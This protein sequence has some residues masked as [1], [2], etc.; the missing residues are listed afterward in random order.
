MKFEHVPLNAEQDAT[1]L[2]CPRSAGVYALSPYPFAAHSAEYAFAGRS[3]ESGQHEKTVA[4]QVCW[5]RHLP[6]GNASVWSRP[7]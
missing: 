5:R 1:I 3:I 6:C 4:G 7:E 2:V